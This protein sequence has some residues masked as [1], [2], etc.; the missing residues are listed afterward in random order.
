MLFE[1]LDSEAEKVEDLTSK[2][3]SLADTVVILYSQGLISKDY[4]EI[5][6]FNSLGDAFLI[7]D[8]NSF[9][10]IFEVMKEK[11]TFFLWKEFYQKTVLQSDLFSEGPLSKRYTNDSL[12]MDMIEEELKSCLVLGKEIKEMFI[13]LISLKFES[14]KKNQTNHFLVRMEDLE[15]F[16]MERAREIMSFLE[17]KELIS[18][19]EN[20]ISEK[21]VTEKNYSD[22][23][24][25]KIDLSFFKIKVVFL[26][27]LPSMDVSLEELIKL[28]DSSKYKKIA[29]EK[30]KE[31]KYY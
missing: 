8:E 22:Y 29:L 11:G 19:T 30:M 2:G 24:K 21:V 25:Q 20:Y 13:S 17:W 28:R 23:I 12:M 31:L 16:C 6:D 4:L 7:G 27:K 1:N 14:F 3:I 15:S 5:L 18:F 10:A 9:L 26:E